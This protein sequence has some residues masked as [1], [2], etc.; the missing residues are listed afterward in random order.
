MVR[1]SVREIEPMFFSERV[2]MTMATNL[3]LQAPLQ[4]M[5]GSSTVSP[6]NLRNSKYILAQVLYFWHHFHQQ[7]G[8][9]TVFSQPWKSYPCIYSV[10][11]CTSLCA[12]SLA[13]PQPCDQAS[14]RVVMTA[15]NKTHHPQTHTHTRTRA[16]SAVV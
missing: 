9:K 6:G 12:S 8:K 2:L 13:R 7:R 16:Q 4:L 11:T 5:R 10:L 1:C 15:E 14:A 3:R